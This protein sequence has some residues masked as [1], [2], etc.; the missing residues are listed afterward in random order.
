M[1]SDFVGHF[2]VDSKVLERVEYSPLMLQYSQVIAVTVVPRH[3]Q[4]AEVVFELEAN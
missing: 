2:E 1:G 4:V 3:S